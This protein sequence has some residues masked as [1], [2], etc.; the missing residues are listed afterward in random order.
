MGSSGC[1]G[2]GV[3]WCALLDLLGTQTAEA[4][5]ST[6]ILVLNQITAHKDEIAPRLTI[7]RRRPRVY[8]FHR[9]IT[10]CRKF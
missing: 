8:E 7:V 4:A 2:D 3:A 9:R 5:V 6:G 1:N 10:A